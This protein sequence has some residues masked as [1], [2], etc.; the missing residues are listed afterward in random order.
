MH[1]ENLENMACCKS[2][3]NMAAGHYWLRASNKLEGACRE[4]CQEVQFDGLCAQAAAEILGRVK[5]E[6]V[7]MLVHHSRNSAQKQWDATLVLALGGMG[8]LLRAHLP[9]VSRMPALP[10]ARACLPCFNASEMDERTVLALGGIT[11][12]PW[13]CSRACPRLPRCAH[14]SRLRTAKSCYF[15]WP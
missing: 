9:L 10:Q 6:S 13:S 2:H 14:G 7:A 8:R 15:D 4:Y 3:C 11:P 5:G 1:F 12:A